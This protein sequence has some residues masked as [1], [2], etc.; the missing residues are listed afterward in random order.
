M[1]GDERLQELS[2]MIGGQ[3][4]TDVTRAQAR[5]LLDSARSEFVPAKPKARNGKPVKSK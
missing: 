4:V 5:E 3:R 2:E 1:E